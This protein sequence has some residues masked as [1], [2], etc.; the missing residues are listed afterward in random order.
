LHTTVPGLELVKPDVDR[1]PPAAVGWLAGDAGRLT[2]RLMG[3]PEEHTGPTTLDIERERV[4]GF[5]DT[6]ERLTWTLSLHGRPVGVI[7][8]DLGPTDHVLAPAVHIMI[9]DPAARGHGVG[10]AALA[11]V[12]DHLSDADEHASLYSRHLTSNRPVTNLLRSAGF[13]NL[14]EPYVDS[15]GLRW[16]NVV[17]DLTHQ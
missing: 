4:Q 10:R 16:Q 8:I 12:I 5:L 7:W 13:R 15:D 11:A 6:R 3:N 9:G 17:L 14:G 2:L 1:D